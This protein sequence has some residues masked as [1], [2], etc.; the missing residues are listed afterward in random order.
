MLFIDGHENPF[1]PSLRVV[2]V[3][4]NLRLPILDA[5]VPEDFSYGA[6]YLVEFEPQSLWYDTSLTIAAQ[7]LKHG[8]KTVYHTL[9]HLPQ[10]IRRRIAEQGV[11][12]EKAED[13]GI[14][15]IYDSYTPSTG[16]ELPEG[17]RERVLGS[18]NLADWST[19]EKRDIERPAEAEKRW[20]HIDDDV[21]VLL[22]YNDEKEFHKSRRD[23]GLPWVRALELVLFQ[24]IA[25]GLFSENLYRQM[26]SVCDGIIEFRTLDEAGRVENYARVR[27][28]R[29]KSL[30]SSWKL[31]KV[32]GNGEVTFDTSHRT[33]A[34]LGIR[35]WVKGP[36]K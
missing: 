36:Q 14:F 25:T 1:S 6:L 9:M 26:E 17:R 28:I 30:D 19:S 32:H 11:D 15:R 3:P 22:Q 4:E 27:M 13:K 7:A 20:L 29:G 34:P 18:V 23:R 8:E 12:L 16:L 33:S 35:A 10:D 31:L 5:L 24:P 21:S 2:A